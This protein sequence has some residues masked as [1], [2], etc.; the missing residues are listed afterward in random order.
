MDENT[1]FMYEV[2][3]QVKGYR[4]RADGNQKVTEPLVELQVDRI[5][6]L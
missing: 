5:L 6:R 4:S 1:K 3:E 2:T